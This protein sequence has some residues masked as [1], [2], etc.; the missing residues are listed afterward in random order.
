MRLTKDDPRVAADL[1]I[2]LS[3]SYNLKVIADYEIGRGAKVTADLAATTIET[4]RRFAA[5][6][7]L[8]LEQPAS[9]P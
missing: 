2:F 7:A 9:H 4:A 8:L 5:Q 6:I 1:R 3:Q